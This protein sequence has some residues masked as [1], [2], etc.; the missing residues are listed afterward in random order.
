MD[1]PFIQSNNELSD[2]IYHKLAH[3]D[4]AIQRNSQVINMVTWELIKQMTHAHVFFISSGSTITTDKC[5]IHYQSLFHRIKI[6][7]VKTFCCPY[8][9]RWAAWA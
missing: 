1:K 3:G 5:N 6:L 2:K 9:V 8:D 7:S 4:T